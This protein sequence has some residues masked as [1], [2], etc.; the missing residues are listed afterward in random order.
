MT[1]ATQFV[2]EGKTLM[3]PIYR[4]EPGNKP[5]IKVDSYHIYIQ[6]K[7][8]VNYLNQ[9][10]S[11]RVGDIAKVV[12]QKVYYK[13]GL[14]NC[15]AFLTI[16]NEGNCDNSELE[17]KAGDDGNAE[18]SRLSEKYKIM[19]ERREKYFSFEH[20]LQSRFGN[21]IPSEEVLDGL[22]R[23]WGK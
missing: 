6:E 2:V 13:N 1:M 14:P 11:L 21:E 16:D 9:Y 15:D 18:K 20:E 12:I 17:K 10:N 3:R 5:V 4:R 19:N 22:R 7:D 8:D 23:K